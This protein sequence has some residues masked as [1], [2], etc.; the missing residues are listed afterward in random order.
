MLNSYQLYHPHHNPTGNNLRRNSL[1]PTISLSKSRRNSFSPATPLILSQP[2]F[3]DFNDDYFSLPSSSTINN[4]RINNN[5]HNNTRSKPIETTTNFFPESK[6]DGSLSFLDSLQL[7]SNLIAS[8]NDDNIFNGKTLPDLS[9]SSPAVSSSPSAIQCV[10]IIRR[11]DTAPIQ[12]NTNTSQRRVVRVIRLSNAARATEKSSSPSSSNVYYVRKSD[13]TPTV[14][15]NPALK[16]VIAQTLINNNNNTDENNQVNK[17]YGSTISIFGIEFAVVSNE[18]NTSDKC[19]SLV[20]NM[21]DTTIKTNVQTTNKIND[22]HKL[23]SRIYRCVL[24]SAEF[25]AYEDFVSHGSGHLQDL[26]LKPLETASVFRRRSYRCLLPHCNARIESETESPR[27]L[28]QLFRRHLLSHVGTH[29]FKCHICKSKFQRIQNYRVH[30]AYHEEMSSPS[31]QCKKCLKKFT[32]DKQYNFHIRK[33]FVVPPSLPTTPTPLFR[34]QMCGENFEK[35]QSLRLHMKHIHPSRPSTP[36]VT[37][38]RS[39]NE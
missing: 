9:T 31:L 15:I 20:Q 6:D 11:N 33:C 32:A 14:Q 27:I 26:T 39:D 18:N 4:N 7:A 3:E 36:T 13:I 12:T 5:N 24:C 25:D 8:T 22:I 28:D 10:R 17:F 34:C 2:T 38:I 30:L 23:F 29:P 37:T 16:H 35:D 1:N 19:A 21:N